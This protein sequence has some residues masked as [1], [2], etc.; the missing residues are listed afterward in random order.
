MGVE[1]DDI[2]GRDGKGGGAT[3]GWDGTFCTPVDVEKARDRRDMVELA[4]MEIDGEDAFR[5]TEA[6][7]HWEIVEKRRKCRRGEKEES[8]KRKEKVIAVSVE[9]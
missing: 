5:T 6:R 8:E 3:L 7:A 4:D 1:L 2:V 9:L